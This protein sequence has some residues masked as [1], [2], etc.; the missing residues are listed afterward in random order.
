MQKPITFDRFIRALISILVLLGLVYLFDYLQNVL[1]PFA[2]AMLMAYFVHPWVLFV[3]KLIKNKTISILTALILFFGIFIGVFII[4]IPIVSKEIGHMGSLLEEFASNRDLQSRMQDYLPASISG[5]VDKILS[6]DEMKEIFKPENPMD[7]W[8]AAAQKLL[9]GLMGVFSGALNVL[10][11]ILGLTVI[12]LYLV[13]ILFDYDAMIHG[14]R[15]Y[16][17]PKRRTLI[18]GI[19]DDF[20]KAMNN[21]FR[22]Q[23]LIALIVGVLFAIGFSI[24]GLPLGIVLGL[25]LGLLNMV[26]YLQTIGILPASISA[27]ILSLET[28]TDFWI[29]LLFVGIVFVVVQL[30]QDAFLTPKIMGKATGLNPAVILLSLSIW[31]KVLGF[32]GLIIALPLTFVLISYYKRIVLNRN[33]F[34]EDSIEIEQKS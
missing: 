28:G 34:D 21:Y 26:P 2:I 13:F 4:L 14:W 29:I 11:A 10:G 16:I 19:V 8:N 7:L 27:L 9:P 31:G 22:A 6:A 1:I 33:K 20:N 15:A 23:S 30:I 24:I 32:L 12:I 17:P 18:L 25:F 5:V 3:Q